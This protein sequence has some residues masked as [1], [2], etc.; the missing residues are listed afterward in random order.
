MEH[1]LASCKARSMF[2]VSRWDE[3]DKALAVA[4]RV[5]HA[6]VAGVGDGGLI[7]YIGICRPAMQ[8]TGFCRFEDGCTLPGPYDDPSHLHEGS[9][10]SRPLTEIRGWLQGIGV[11]NCT[12]IRGNVLKTMRRFAIHH[13][14]LTHDGLTVA[15]A[16]VDLNLYEPT[17]HALSILLPDLVPSGIVLV[18]DVAYPGGRTALDECGRSW[19]HC[20]HMARFVGPPEGDQ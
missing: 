14:G 17:R 10:A 6:C 5:G 13:D 9:L 20:C 18:D 4:P 11:H 8:V 16:V 3:L 1:K 19:E 7:G 12:L 15:L 2:D